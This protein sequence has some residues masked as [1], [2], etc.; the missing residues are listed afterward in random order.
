MQ[1]PK[2]IF[3]LNYA[4]NNGCIYCHR[5]FAKNKNFDGHVEHVHLYNLCFFT[6]ATCKNTLGDQLIHSKYVEGWQKNILQ[7][8]KNYHPIFDSYFGVNQIQHSNGYRTK[9]IM[10]MKNIRAFLCPNFCCGSCCS[11]K[12]HKSHYQHLQPEKFHH[13]YICGSDTKIK[14]KNS[15]KQSYYLKQ[16]YFVRIGI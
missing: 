2:D 16:Y 14:L 9:C 7:K 4:K 5:R 13:T 1:I 8:M 6:C 10:C 15:P 11:C 3:W 12:Y